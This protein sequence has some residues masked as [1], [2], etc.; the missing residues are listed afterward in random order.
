MMMTL[1]RHMFLF[2][3][4]LIICD[5]FVSDLRWLLKDFMISKM[6][7]VWWRRNIHVFILFKMRFIIFSFSERKF[8]HLRGKGEMG[9]FINKQITRIYFIMVLGCRYKM[10]IFKFKF[11]S[12]HAYLFALLLLLLHRHLLPH[13]QISFK[14]LKH[15]TKHNIFATMWRFEI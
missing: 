15:H 14:K 10:K 7:S 8:E 2:H 6:E 9:N 5:I 1:Y 3:F 13:V 4:I 12:F 11:P